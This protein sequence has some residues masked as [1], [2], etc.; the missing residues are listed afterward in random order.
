MPVIYGEGTRAV[1]RLLEHVL[2]GS[3]DAT[4]LAW[5]GIA[6][7][8]NSCLPKDLTVYDEVVPLHIPALME[9][10]ELDRTV[11]GL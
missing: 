5:T 4:I 11:R 7:D 1:G 6:N 2:T 3:G 10:G 9:M 8:Y